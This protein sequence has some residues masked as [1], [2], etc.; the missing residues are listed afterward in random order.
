VVFG[1]SRTGRRWLDA[2]FEKTLRKLI[3]NNGY[4][5]FYPGMGLVLTIL[6]EK[7]LDVRKS[8]IVLATVTRE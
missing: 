5:T 1:Y 3:S 6:D 4:G 8:E 2:I 7:N